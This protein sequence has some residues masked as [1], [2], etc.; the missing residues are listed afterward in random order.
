MHSLSLSFLVFC[1]FNQ[2]SL[3][4]LF[5]L[6][7]SHSLLYTLHNRAVS[8]VCFSVSMHVC[9]GMCVLMKLT[10]PSELLHPLRTRPDKQIKY[11]CSAIVIFSQQWPSAETPQRKYTKTNKQCVSAYLT[12][13][14]VYNEHVCLFVCFVFL[15][16]RVTTYLHVMGLIFIL[17][18]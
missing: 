5:P 7:V 16:C 13:G 15:Y 3:S 4:S 10:N 1:L 6:S 2:D 12:C 8:Q 14:T 18:C 9:V 17:F 11:A